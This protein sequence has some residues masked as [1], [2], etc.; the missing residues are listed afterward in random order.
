MQDINDISASKNQIPNQRPQPAPK[1]TGNQKHFPIVWI[2]VI[3]ILVI[4]LAGGGVVAYYFLRVLPN[5]EKKAETTT[6]QTSTDETAD[7]QTYTNSTDNFSFKYPKDWIEFDKDCSGADVQVPKFVVDVSE[8]VRPEEYECNIEFLAWGFGVMVSDSE[9]DFAE[10]KKDTEMTFSDVKISGQ[11]A[12][13]GVETSPAGI[14]AS[15]YVTN[16]Y[17][18]YK[19]KGWKITW[20]NEDEAGNHDETFDKILKTFKLD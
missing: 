9:F 13:K 3:I 7:W 4:L 2:F 12:L 5:N 15:T 19:G 17:F 18:N 11:N 14:N 16:H 10:L 6:T 8:Q 1:Q 20:Q